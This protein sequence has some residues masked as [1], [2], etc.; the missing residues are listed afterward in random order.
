MR[1]RFLV[2]VAFWNEINMQ[3]L[4]LG[5]LARSDKNK[6]ERRL[7]CMEVA[8]VVWFGTLLEAWCNYEFKRFF[9][10]LIPEHS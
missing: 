3:G 10:N 1:V 6:T 8:V 2:C 7:G 9:G 5:G 4:M